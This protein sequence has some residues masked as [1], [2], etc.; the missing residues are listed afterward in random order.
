MSLHETYDHWSVSA[1]TVTVRFIY[2]HFWF[3]F[4]LVAFC[5]ALNMLTP[6]LLFPSKI[7]DLP[8]LSV[9]KGSLRQKEIFISFPHLTFSVYQQKGSFWII[10]ILELFMQMSTFTS[11]SHLNSSQW[12]QRWAS[13]SFPSVFILHWLTRFHNLNIFWPSFHSWTLHFVNKDG[14]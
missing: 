13:T 5:I 6:I 11:L 12:K 9:R 3:F 10:F 14:L 2:S 4:K 8:L 1:S 7:M